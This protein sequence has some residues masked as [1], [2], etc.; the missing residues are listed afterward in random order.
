M[1][2]GDSK[3][4]LYEVMEK[5]KGIDRINELLQQVHKLYQVRPYKISKISPT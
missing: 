1:N 2:E 3:K 4:F 5:Y